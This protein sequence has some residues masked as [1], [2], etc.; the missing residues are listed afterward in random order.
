VPGYLAGLATVVAVALLLRA[1]RFG[2]VPT[3]LAVGAMAVT[4]MFWVYGRLGA[5]FSVLAGFAAVVVHLRRT[6]RPGRNAV[7][8]AAVLA[9]LTVLLSWPGALGG[10][11]FWTWLWRRRGFDRV[12]RWVMTGWLAGA[13]LLGLWLFGSGAGGDLVAQAS[14]R[15]A[16][17][18]PARFAERQWWFATELFTWWW[19]LLLVPAL[20]AGVRDRRTRAPVVITASL[21]ALWTLVPTDAAFIHDFWNLMWLLPAA[22]GTAALAD[23]AAAKLGV[24]PIRALAATAA[25]AVVTALVGVASGSY[26][27]RYFESPAEAGA[28]L[29]QVTPPPGLESVAVGAEIALPRWA[30]WWW[31]VPVFV[32][33]PGNVGWLD[34]GTPVLIRRDD[35]D[36]DPPGGALLGARGDYALIPARVLAA[37]EP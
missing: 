24:R 9:G 4:P 7:A 10:V 32:I 15:V 11:L 35:W 30:S 3:L 6:E 23:L 25:V 17:L 34:P 36:L 31:G 19:L 18:N 26:P 5:G 27:E 2:W 28:L 14:E 37:T 8:V 29:Q 22:I 33:T 20:Y 1:L 13:A 16:S 12:S 21:A